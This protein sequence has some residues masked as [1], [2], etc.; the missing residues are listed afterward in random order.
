ML[1]PC[2][3][4]AP[5][6]RQARGFTLIELLITVAVMV[7]LIAVA[8]PSY[9]SAMRKSRRTEAF[10]ALTQ[11]QQMQERHRSNSASYATSLTAAATATPPGLGMA[12]LT[13]G[14]FYDLSL[15]GTTTAS[16]YVAI[17][18]GVSGTSQ[19]ADGA[20]KVLAVRSEGANLRYGSGASTSALDWT[21]ANPDPGRCWAR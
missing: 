7:L 16:S 5:A 2:R 10:H 8:L 14:G 11:I 15:G 4:T 3:H 20:C 6:Q 21:L 19:A 1:K 13:P 18:E 9:Q 17:A 12:A